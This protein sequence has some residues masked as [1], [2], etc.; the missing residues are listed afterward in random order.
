[1]SKQTRKKNKDLTKKIAEERIL[2]LFELAEMNH[3]IHPERAQRYVTLARLISMRYN[4]RL[5]REQKR[6]ICQHCYAYLIPGKNC[7][8]RM[9]NGFVLTT[10]FECGGQ[11]RIPYYLK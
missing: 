10:C 4:V 2:K 7:R 9:K 1:M 11:R 5:E 3:E 6:K 8:V